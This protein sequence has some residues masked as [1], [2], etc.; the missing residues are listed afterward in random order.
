MDRVVPMLPEVLSNGVCSLVPGEDRLAFSVFLTFDRDGRCVARRFAKSVI[1]SQARFTYEQ[2]M[3]M[4]SGNRTRVPKRQVETVLDVHRLAQQLRSMRFAAGALDLEVPETEIVLDEYGASVGMVSLEDLL[5]EIVGEIR[6]EYDEDEKDLIQKISEREYL[7]EGSVKLDDINDALELSLYSDDYDSI[8][9]L[10]I[11]MLDHLPTEQE[12]VTT[13]D[14]ISLTVD[15]MSKNRI[16]T[17][18]L[19][20]PEENSNTEDSD[21]SDAP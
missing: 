2:V 12:S 8:G 16:E 4:I 1:R 15:K 19:L 21:P 17:V 20:L 18:R 3:S 10:I 5:E 6:D 9:G 14:G 13:E 7:I 11:E